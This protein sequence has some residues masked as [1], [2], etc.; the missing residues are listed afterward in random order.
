MPVEY[1]EWELAASLNLDSRTLVTRIADSLRERIISGQLEPGAHIR[2]DE[3]AD[4]FG[5]S[6]TP[7]REAFRL[8]AAEG[9]VTIRPRSGV[10]VVRISAAE[11]QDI[12][13]MRLL[14]E[15]LAIRVAALTHTEEEAATL[16][17][18][19]CRLQAE[20]PREQGLANEYDAANQ[21]FHFALYGLKLGE[22]S[23]PLHVSLRG[24]WER[25]SR[26]RRVYYSRA[27][28]SLSNSSD[29][30]A[31]LIDAW[32]ARDADRAEAILAQHILYAGCSLVRSLSSAEPPCYA[33]QLVELAK[34]YGC[35]LGRL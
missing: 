20:R 27:I 32:L 10:E 14:L 30:H 23:D 21:E 22:T 4:A 31:A 15:P 1:G 9:W 8:L 12:V 5:V 33:A 6:R 26:Y 19:H 2:Q 13:A 28:D 16:Q 3:Y 17:K 29:E 24:Y 34:R 7:L 35:D 25:Y 11:V 18:G